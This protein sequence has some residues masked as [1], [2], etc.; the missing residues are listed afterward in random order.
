MKSDEE[1]I[2]FFTPK[3]VYKTQQHKYSAI[4]MASNQIMIAGTKSGGLLG[5]QLNLNFSVNVVLEFLQIFKTPITRIE[6]LTDW[7]NLFL[8]NDNNLYYFNTDK[9]KPKELLKS[10]IFYEI[11]KESSNIFLYAAI[12]NKIIKFQIND[13]FDVNKESKD[14]KILKEFPFANQIK[15]GAMLGDCVIIEFVNK[16][17]EIVNLVTLKSK[18]SNLPKSEDILIAAIQSKE[19]LTLRRFDNENYISIFLGEDGSPAKARNSFMVNTM[20]RNLK[21]GTSQSK[22]SEKI[23]RVTSSNNLLVVTSLAGSHVFNLRDNQ[24]LQVINLDGEFNDSFYELVNDNL[25]AVTESNIYMFKKMKIE[26]LF[27]KTREKL[28]YRTGVSILK[29][30]EEAEP[31][32][33]QSYINQLYSHCGWQYL[34]SNRFK[35]ATECFLNIPFDPCEVIEKVIPNYSIN[36]PFQLAAYPNQLKTFIKTVFRRRREEIV[37]RADR[38]LIRATEIFRQFRSEEDARV[39]LWLIAIDYAFIR[40]N[41][42]LKTLHDLFDFLRNTT[43]IHCDNRNS[44]ITSLFKELN[45]NKL[46]IGEVEMSIQAELNIVIKNKEAAL[47]KFREL[48]LSESEKS[49][50][51]YQVYSK[52][53]GLEVLLSMQFE[54][55]FYAILAENFDWITLKPEGLADFFKKIKPTEKNMAQIIDCIDR[56]DPLNTY[57]IEIKNSFLSNLIESGFQGNNHIN[58]EFFLTQIKVF[59]K[60]ANPKVLQAAEEFLLSDNRSF[61]FDRLLIE[62]R[63]IKT[64]FRKGVLWEDYII[65]EMFFIETFIMHRINRL[66]IHEKAIDMIIEKNEIASAED[67]C[68]GTGRYSLKNTTKNQNA[69]NGGYLLNTLLDKYLII[70][71]RSEQKEKYLRI[72]NDFLIK[73]AGNTNIDATQ[74]IQKLPDDVLIVDASFDL[75]KFVEATLVEGNAQQKEKNFQINVSEAYLNKVESEIWDHKKKWVKIDNDS[76]CAKCGTRILSK[77]FDVYPNGVVVDHFCSTAMLEA[78]KC[79]LSGQNFSKTTWV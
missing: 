10:V 41:I 39:D 25:F 14:Y 24:F 27:E 45:D 59:Q 23:T 16:Q 34:M 60:S 58:N 66:E 52:Q 42:E 17:I 30:Y 77:V 9:K 43:Q 8:T 19:I 33:V 28:N 26:E 49:R 29:I 48:Y 54:D 11:V 64:D 6:C 57:R 55:T 37:K 18:E 47:D 70:C 53:R 35:E 76:Y 38:N 51:D 68:A 36:K 5:Y 21:E 22:I 56:I 15:S 50:F 2:D 1:H 72:I 31:N 63:N 71:K 65:S 74:V 78:D 44:A 32:L 12:K 20:M 4:K 75:F 7:H 62:Y 13:F 79:P 73:F 3:S 69:Q 46:T 67:Y 40:A 61:D